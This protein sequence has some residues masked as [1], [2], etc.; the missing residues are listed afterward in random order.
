M[1]DQKRYSAGLLAESEINQAFTEAAFTG[2]EPR[3]AP[4][5]AFPDNGRSY[6]G[7]DEE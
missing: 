7:P 2:G 5:Q 4:W 1:E 6:M 3:K